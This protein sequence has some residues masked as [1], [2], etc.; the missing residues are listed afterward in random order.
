MRVPG[1]RSRRAAGIAIAFV[2][3]ATLLG[4]YT[5]GPARAARTDVRIG[6]AAPASLD[7]AG[8]SDIE[9]AALAAQ[10]FETLTTFDSRLV[11][12]PALAAGWDVSSDGR[13]VVFHLRPNLEFSD[14]SPLT[15]DDVVRSWLRIVD[16]AHPS[17]LVTLML[18][19]KGVREH[20][21][22][23]PGTADPGTVGIHARGSDVVVD[24]DRPGADFPSI[25]A[26]PTFAVV[27]P[28][29]CSTPNLVL[30]QCGVGSG[31][32]SLNAVTDSELTLVANPH[33]WA[34]TPA[35]ATIHVR[36]DI[37]GRSPV[38]AFSAGDVDYA[39]IAPN[40]ASWIRF[41]ATLGPSL[42]EVPSL[43]LT[44]LG[45][46]TSRPPFNDAKVRQAIAGAVD[47]TRVVQLGAIAGDVPADSMVPPGI[48]GRD[49]QR[50]LPPHDPDAARALLTQAGFPGGNGFPEVVL[51][52]GAFAQGIAADLKR[53]L[54]ITVRLEL[55]DDYFGRLASDPPAMWTLDW[56]ADYPGENDFLGVLLG[57]GSPSNYGRWSSTAFDDAITSA[58]TARD[59]GAASGAFATA[60]GVVASDVPTIPISYPGSAWALSRDGLLGAGQNGLGIPRYAG[61]AWAP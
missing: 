59:P 48:P 57:T 37:G 30:G 7:P 51:A 38:D 32:Y 20:L 54:G 27:P 33:Y 10:L 16:P 46:D 15:A 1:R 28:F 5:I 9:S 24:L 13:Q 23:A 43:S 44:Y 22:G 26:S 2:A 4:T 50:W 61:L 41:D 25:V 29:T 6:A 34:G 60:L 19:V 58:Q 8:Q 17:P 56:I 47:W 14:G 53:E 55:Y 12:R 36:T 31:G 39:S 40:D 3:V 42:R 45:F 35:M 18:D 49:S 21:S 11:L 52:G